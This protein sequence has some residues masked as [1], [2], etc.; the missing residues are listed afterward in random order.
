MKRRDLAGTV[1]DEIFDG[2][3]R[4]FKP[5]SAGAS[6]PLGPEKKGVRLHCRVGRVQW[7]FGSVT[8][9]RAL[10]GP[11]LSSSQAPV[12]CLRSLRAGGTAQIFLNKTLA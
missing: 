1:P 9:P 6:F 7:T 4:Y 5:P 11:P 10:S 2:V 3:T 12:P 8:D